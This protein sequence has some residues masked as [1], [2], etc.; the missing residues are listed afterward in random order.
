V[1]ADEIVA[2]CD[3]RTAGVEHPAMTLSG[4]NLQK[5]V[6]GRALTQDPLAI[7]VAQPTWGVDANAQAAIHERLRALAARGAAVLVISQDLDELMVLS[8]R[9]AVI[10]AGQLS[11]ARPVGELTVEDIGLAMAATSGVAARGSLA[12]ASAA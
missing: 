1:R 3:V 2:A 12:G 5:F 7:V 11:V 10:A 9:I 6:V 8:D 4:G